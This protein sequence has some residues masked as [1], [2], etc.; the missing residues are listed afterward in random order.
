MELYR[1]YCD[2]DGKISGNTWFEVRQMMPNFLKGYFIAVHD[3]Y[4]YMTD[5]VRDW[6]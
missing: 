1:P 3:G 4:G 5:A 2:T 6:K